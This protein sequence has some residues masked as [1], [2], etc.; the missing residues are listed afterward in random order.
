[1]EEQLST[2]SFVLVIIV[3]LSM[4][5]TMTY[6]MAKLI[7]VLSTHKIK[8]KIRKIDLEQY[9]ILYCYKGVPRTLQSKQN[10]NEIIYL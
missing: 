9:N 3:L 6:L 5:I 2:L 7:H 10:P 8:N 4:S 1:M